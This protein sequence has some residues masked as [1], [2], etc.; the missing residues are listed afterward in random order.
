MRAAKGFRY[1]LLPAVVSLV[2]ACGGG[3]AAP[4]LE[5]LTLAGKIVAPDAADATVTVTVGDESFE[6][7]TDSSGGYS[8]RV[9]VDPALA[10][11]LV[12]VL[13]KLGDDSSFIELL[14]RVGTLDD[15]QADA[16]ADGALNAAENIRTNVSSLSTAEAALVEEAEAG[17]GK[18]FTFGD[19]V[20]PEE[21]LK[22][23]ALLQLVSSDRDNFA[24]PEGTTTT[25]ELARNKDVREAFVAEVETS[26]PDDFE[27]AKQDLVNN[28]DIIGPA[29]ASDVP[30]DLLAA[31]LEIGGNY[32]FN[33]NGLVDGLEFDADGTGRYFSNVRTVGMSWALD[34]PRI[35]VD[36]DTPVV[37]TSFEFVDCDG[38]GNVIQ[39]ESQISQS[40]LD[41]ARLSSTAVSVT[42]TSTITTPDCPA[43]PSSTKTET[44]A[45]TVLNDETL[46]D[47]PVADVS[48][49]SL[50]LPVVTTVDQNGSTQLP[51]DLVAFSADG[52]GSGRFTAPGF[53]WNVT[54][55]VLN[56]DYGNGVLGRYRPVLGIDGI[57][58]AV[59]AD[60][61]TPNGRFAD[62]ALSFRVDPSFA[63]V[64]S[65]VPARYFQFGVG[66]EN[67]GDP[68][69][70]GFR[71]R[72]DG[73]GTGSQEDDF[74]DGSDQV[75][76]R[77]GP[78]LAFQWSLAGSGEV[79]VRR[80]YD[81]ADGS[82]NCDPAVTQTC[83]L[84][85]QRILVPVNRAGERYYWLERRRADDAGVDSSDP[86]SFISRFYDRVPLSAAKLQIPAAAGADVRIPLRA[87]RHGEMAR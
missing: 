9:E 66:L 83:V 26:K 52:S 37:S 79:V 4:K 49:L 46:Q 14:S 41:V 60:F 75:A 43:Q 10:S 20:D 84:F 28:V 38:S 57:A 33:N 30:P 59:L 74:I 69:L 76:V 65:E 8:V 87:W 6:T 15:L 56:V 27:Q 85:D 62:L 58:R 54:G 67:G 11:G 17:S 80:Y 50:T 68:R 29:M 71:L 18:S 16:G 2:S 13:A 7:K 63:F 82:G 31:L 35:R 24:L 73:D 78:F 3:D 22:L 47:F 81:S 40:G 39:R 12:S 5:I 32:P 19:G 77:A 44:L 21:A 55:G 53:A 25:L 48:G 36:F 86:Q 51:D 23:A 64:A 72:F 61:Q 42:K 70:E 1:L 45:K 34:G